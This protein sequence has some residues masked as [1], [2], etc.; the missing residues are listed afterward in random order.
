MSVFANLIFH[1]FSTMATNTDVT[2]ESDALGAKGN[3]ILGLHFWNK[4]PITL[5]LFWQD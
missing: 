1:V 2:K 4:L 3:N 5:R